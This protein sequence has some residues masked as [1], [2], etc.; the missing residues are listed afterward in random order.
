MTGP[1]SDSGRDPIDNDD[2]ISALGRAMLG[3]VGSTPTGTGSK[4]HAQWVPPAPAELQALLPGYE[5][6][7]MLGRGGMGAVYMARQRSLDRAV[8]IKILSGA[9]A[10]A[11]GD[12]SFAER[13][14]N[15]ARAMARLSHPGIVSIFDFGET[16]D[17]LLYIVMEYIDGTDVS[18]M[19]AAEGRLHTEHA[20]AIAAH[21]CDALAYAHSE[22]I[23]HRDIK[24]ANIMVGYNGVVKVADFGLA[25]VRTPDG[26]SAGLTLSGLAMGTMHFIAPEALAGELVV[27]HRADLYAVGAMLYQMLTG[28][29]P[30][31]LFELP[32]MQVPGLDP[33]YDKI[34]AQAMREDRE[35]RY[36]D[37]GALRRDLDAILTQPVAKVEADDAE[38]APTLPAMARPHRPG[39]RGTKSA[40]AVPMVEK[41]GRMSVVWMMVIALFV[42]GGVKWWFFGQEKPGRTPELPQK[43][44]AASRQ[45]ANA[46]TASS[47]P[48]NATKDTPFVNSLGMK[49]V[50]VL[51]TGGPT[52]GKRVLFSIWETRVQDYETFVADTG[53]SWPTTTFPQ[54][55]THPAVY[56]SWDDAQVFCAWLSDREQMAGQIGTNERYRL[57]TDHEW[58]CAAGI[59]EREDPALSPS[60]KDGVVRD[61]YPWG[62]LWPPPEDAGNYS[63]EEAAGHETYTMQKI[64]TGY[65]DPFP[66][67]APVGSFSANANGLYD[68]GGNIAE[69]C[70]ELVGINDDSRTLRGGSFSSGTHLLSSNRDSI[71]QTDR[72][73]GKGFRIVLAPETKISTDNTSAA[74]ETPDTSGPRRRISGF[75]PFLRARST[76]VPARP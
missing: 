52:S 17:G 46:G 32:S 71:F 42:A 37:A 68:I 4:S 74:P 64:L 6:L 23:I 26:H 33:R 58:S 73:P 47:S 7:K 18:R 34:I 45:A 24:P 22:G 76:R 10:E 53:R 19:I 75:A 60:S 67:T 12:Y 27:D 25:K 30:H 5:I 11:E 39:R 48:A 51:I 13:F 50:P 70:E 3:G 65:R 57:P 8:A 66:E 29:L 41:G 59:G 69:W 54:G 55:P 44:T 31:G 14:K 38:A 35:E 72:S 40:P 21:V 20:M 36:Q 28:K 63:G 9:L 56:T 62:T 49:F 1:P 15:E 43:P 2:D 16:S 61:V